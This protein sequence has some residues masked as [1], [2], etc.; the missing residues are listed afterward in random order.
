MHELGIANSLLEAVRTE[1]ARHPGAVVRKVG[2]TVGELAGVDP[3]ALAFGFEAIVNGPS[4]GIWCWRFRPGGGCIA[5]PH[6]GS[7]S[8]WSITSLPARNAALR[9]PNASAAMN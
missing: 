2:V 8:V 7:R 3:E 9:R 5:A 1:A 6:A 4:G